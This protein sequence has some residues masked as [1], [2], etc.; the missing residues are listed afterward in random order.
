M[1]SRPLPFCI[2]FCAVLPFVIH[3][4]AAEIS[5]RRL[6]TG[7]N[8]TQATI[9]VFAGQR[10]S[11]PVP[12]W[13]TGKFAEHLHENIYN[14]MFAEILCNPTLANYPFAAEGMEPD[15]AVKFQTNE[16][17]IFRA[18]RQR[19]THVG[20]PE[21]E[22]KPLTEAFADGLAAFWTWEGSRK[23]VLPSPDTGKF[24]GRAQRVQVKA[25]GEGIA[26]W[27][28]LPLHRVRK[29]EFEIFVRSPDMTNL[30]ISLTPVNAEKP[31]VRAELKSI[32]PQW[33]KFNGTLELDAA[34]PADA[35]Y[36]LAL[37]S[38]APGQFVVQHIFLQPADNIHGSDPD[39]IRYLKEAHLPLL[40]WPGG[41]FASSYHWRDGI[42]PVEQRPA[43]PNLAWGGVE[44]NLFGTDE[45]IEF[46]RAVGCEPMICINGGDGT[47]GEAAQWID[48]C[49]GPATSPMGKLRAANGHPK[50]YAVKNWEVGNEL[51]GHWQFHWTTAEGY[52][53]R[54][55]C[56]VAALHKADSTINLYACGAPVFLDMAWDDTLI[57]RDGS[58]IQCI[59][60]HPLI[61]GNV[62]SAADPLEVYADFMAVPEILGQKW[63]VLRDHMLQGGI[64][65]PHL[66][67][68]ELQLFVHLAND[69]NASSRLTQQNLPSQPTITEAIYDALIYHTAIRLGPFVELITHSAIVNHGG[70]LRKQHERVY[71]EPAYYAQADF[72]AFAGATP[73]ALN[74][75]SALKHAP[76]VISDLKKFASEADY[77][78]VD[79]VAA[80]AGD[81]SLLLSLVNRDDKA[82]QLTTEL[83]HFHPAP[84]AEV[85][86][87]AAD[88][89]WAANSLEKP[90]AIQPVNSTISLQ[91]R[92]LEMTLP[93]YSLVRVRIPAGR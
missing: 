15:G 30:S 89:P 69:T 75:A 19:A 52:A 11:T 36:K 23:D 71:P 48:Y 6:E 41:N 40:R 21:S 16:E 39:I 58:L 90:D 72:A 81:G 57:R 7:T 12:V 60:D 3:A 46:C 86:T 35:A 53:D 61:G 87:L 44:P 64:S 47:P 45:Y 62:S 54:Y 43:R 67:V 82:I 79:A 17:Q 25:A 76:C 2:L 10:A 49:N 42:G 14:G 4:R 5:L 34:A 68:T 56:F 9:T 37:T 65:S 92:K 55:R 31:A 24:G 18:L 13:L 80:I 27:T 91:G 77:S 70:G 38:D 20:W 22:L 1:I 88:V 85:W 93:P 32:S 29:Y 74:I 28:Y 33:Q 8:E 26:Q 78:S 73:V 50:P 51:W 84:T 66:A 59:T 83:D 63:S